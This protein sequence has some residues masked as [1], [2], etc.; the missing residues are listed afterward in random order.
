MEESQKQNK[1]PSETLTVCT[2][3]ADED[4]GNNACLFWVKKNRTD[5]SDKPLG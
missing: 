5:Y 3:S 4:F 2:I 1:H